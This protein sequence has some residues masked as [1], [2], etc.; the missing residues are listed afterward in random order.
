M[1]DGWIDCIRNLNFTRINK[2]QRRK[3][4]LFCRDIDGKF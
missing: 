2:S 4:D 3:F 1:V